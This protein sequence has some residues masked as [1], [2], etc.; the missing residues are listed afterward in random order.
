M[1]GGVFIENVEL[2]DIYKILLSMQQ[3]IHRLDKKVDNIDM[4][5]TKLEQRLE[6]VQTELLKEIQ[7]K[8]LLISKDFRNTRIQLGTLISWPIFPNQGHPSFGK[9]RPIGD[10]LRHPLGK[11]KLCIPQYIAF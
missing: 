9:F 2:V 6:D 3:D 10:G 5:L 4:R 8:K 11:K 7:R 1:K